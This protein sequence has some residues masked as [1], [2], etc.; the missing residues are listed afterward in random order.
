MLKELIIHLAETPG[1]TTSLRM[2]R[3]LTAIQAAFDHGH[4]HESIH[5]TLVACGL[6]L[7][8]KSYKR[9]LFRL[10]KEESAKIDK[11]GTPGNVPIIG[12]TRPRESVDR[13]GK[14]SYNVPPALAGA[15]S[16]SSQ[17]GKSHSATSDK[18]TYDLNSVV[19]FFEQGK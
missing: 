10:R 7:T 14:A 16:G 4:T 2:R 9:I 3:S 6:S 1:R 12:T 8:F 5:A 11:V 18:L 17:D 13:P 15:T 19:N